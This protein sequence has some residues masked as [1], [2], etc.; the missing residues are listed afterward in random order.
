MKTTTSFTITLLAAALTILPATVNAQFNQK[1]PAEIMREAQERQQAI[2]Q[3][4]RDMQR[5]LSKIF[6]EKEAQEE[7]ERQLQKEEAR[8]AKEEAR[9]QR[10]RE[11]EA[12]QQKEENARLQREREEQRQAAAREQEN[13]KYVSTPREPMVSSPSGTTSPG[14]NIKSTSNEKGW[15]DWQLI[16]GTMNDGGIDVRTRKEGGAWISWGWQFRNRY[17]Q[18]VTVRYSR[19]NG[20]GIRLDGCWAPIK[21]LSESAPDTNMG[22]DLKPDVQI[23][24]VDFR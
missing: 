1:S 6:E 4:G 14:Q 12:Q 19:M 15:S 13:N 9:I 24:K 3:A 16:Y 17:N 18:P 11:A 8:A 23:I 21:A 20:K 7:R 22:G 10:E 5:D 2:Q